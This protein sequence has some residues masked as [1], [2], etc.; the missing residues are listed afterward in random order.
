MHRA[1]HIFSAFS[2]LIDEIEMHLK[3]DD[4]FENDVFQEQFSPIFLLK[5]LYQHGQERSGCGQ[6]TQHYYAPVADLD[7]FLFSLFDGQF[8]PIHKMSLFSQMQIMDMN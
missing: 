7:H 4:I 3:S 6:R 1:A 2:L 5:V 8:L